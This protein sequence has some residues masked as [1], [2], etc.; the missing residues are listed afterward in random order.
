MKSAFAADRA[1]RPNQAVG[2]G[3]P[4]VTQLIGVDWSVAVE[5][6]PTLSRRLS[7]SPAS[8][9]PPLT[10]V[11]G[12]PGPDSER[13]CRFRVLLE[14]VTLACAYCPQIPSKLPA[15]IAGTSTG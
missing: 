10:K 12:L 14:V 4:A 3:C 15:A 1:V 11:A 6:N 2:F 9:D 5:G 8:G 7:S 13:V